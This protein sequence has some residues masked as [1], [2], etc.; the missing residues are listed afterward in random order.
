[1][2]QQFQVLDHLA[3][4]VRMSSREH[5]GLEITP[6][7]EGIPKAMLKDV[8]PPLGPASNAGRTF[9]VNS[10][11]DSSEITYTLGSLEV[12]TWARSN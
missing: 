10:F 4:R 1:M 11:Y 7:C 5:L 2:M 9:L 3:S 8:L 12:G 6:F